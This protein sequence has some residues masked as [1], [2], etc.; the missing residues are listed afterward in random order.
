MIYSNDGKFTFLSHY[1]F[2]RLTVVTLEFWRHIFISKV[3]RAFCLLIL[4]SRVLSSWRHGTTRSPH[5]L[6]SLSS[7]RRMISEPKIVGEETIFSHFSPTSICERITF[8]KKNVISTD[9]FCTS[10]RLSVWVSTSVVLARWAPI[11]PQ[12][13]CLNLYQTSLS[14]KREP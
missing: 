4:D 10:T 3:M 12:S 6:I 8:E 11:T 5:N 2:H 14:C 9:Y 7:W 13:T 1:L